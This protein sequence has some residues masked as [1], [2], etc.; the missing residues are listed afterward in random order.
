MPRP[1][2]R[3]ALG[4]ARFP[5]RD[6]AAHGCRVLMENGKPLVK[7][8]PKFGPPPKTLTPGEIKAD[9]Q[10]HGDKWLAGQR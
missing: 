1:G 8:L 4:P 6:Y 5:R 9:K 10:I 2:S 3:D 7:D